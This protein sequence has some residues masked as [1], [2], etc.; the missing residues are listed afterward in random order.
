M[1]VTSKADPMTTTRRTS[2]DGH[3]RQFAQLQV[4][5]NQIGQPCSETSTRLPSTSLIQLSAMAP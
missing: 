4:L 3:A 1:A 2:P 5:S